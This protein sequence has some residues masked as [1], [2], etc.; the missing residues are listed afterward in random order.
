MPASGI[1]MHN[2]EVNDLLVRLIQDEDFINYRK[3]SMFIALGYCDWKCCKEA[4]I[5]ITVCQ[6]S[7]LAKQKEIEV[8]VDEIFHRYIQNP[9]TKAIVIGGLE[10]LT[11][12]SEVLSLIRYF[13]N[14]GCD[15]DFVIYTGYY[16]TEIPR[17]MTQLLMYKNIVVKQGRFIPDRPKRYDEV[18]GVTLASDNQYAERIN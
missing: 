5:P 18:L 8:S 17:F 9:I 11:K 13:R 14:N 10:P 16:A 3:A 12:P 4:N 7:E 1:L 15:D 2:L 6:N